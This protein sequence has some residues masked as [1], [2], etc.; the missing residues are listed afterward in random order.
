[1]G[2][3]PYHD[4][5]H[6]SDRESLEWMPVLGSFAAV[7]PRIFEFLSIM[8]RTRARKIWLPAAEQLATA[9]LT[10]REILGYLQKKWRICYPEGAPHVDW[11]VAIEAQ[12][13]AP[14]DA[15]PDELIEKEDVSHLSRHILYAACF[16]VSQGGDPDE[17]HGFR[18]E[19][20][21][22]AG[23]PKN[24]SDASI[25]LNCYRTLLGHE[26]YGPVI[27]QALPK[28][29]GRRYSDNLV[30]EQLRAI[31][32]QLEK[33]L[34]A[35]SPALALVSRLEDFLLQP[36]WNRQRGNAQIDGLWSWGPPG[37]TV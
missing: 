11:K 16:Y 2:K 3:W 1:M 29:L 20:F 26:S 7:D 4:P 8:F 6:V 33:E 25:V 37:G 9:A 18:I 34:P 21:L 10:D 24:L 32:E 13:P 35:G 14:G 30:E 22:S 17:F 19:P 12:T 36:H 28:V 15:D 31:T 23:V 5:L 27:W